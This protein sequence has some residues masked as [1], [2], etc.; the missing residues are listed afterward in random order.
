MSRFYVY[1]FG[2]VV[3][4]GFLLLAAC[5]GGEEP[6]PTVAPPATIAMA[7]ATALP[8]P[9]A[10]PVQPTQ[11]PPTAVPVQPTQAPPP[12]SVPVEPTQVPVP[13]AAPEEPTQVPPTTTSGIEIPAFVPASEWTDPTPGEFTREDVDYIFPPGRGQDLVFQGCQGCHNWVPLVVSGFDRGGWYQNMV[14]HKERATGM[15]DADYEYLYEYLIA[16]WPSDRPVPDG[17]PQELLDQ[18]TS[19]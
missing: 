5:G 2:S 17:I 10:V 18:W 4:V 1:G 13:T 3:L 7:P 16:T 11:V 8:P 9:T 6:T 19:Y 15:S 12:T 14:N